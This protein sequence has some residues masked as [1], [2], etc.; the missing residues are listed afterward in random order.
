MGKIYTDW[1][2]LAQAGGMYCETTEDPM[3]WRSG[4]KTRRFEELANFDEV[5]K[6]L[7]LEVEVDY[8]EG[9]ALVHVKNP[10]SAGRMIL[11]EN[12]EVGSLVRYASSQEGNL[13]DLLAEYGQHVTIE[14]LIGGNKKR[15]RVYPVP[16]TTH[17]NT[18]SNIVEC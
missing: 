13:T 12:D 2:E 15:L 10:D 3:G 7:G 11:S 6:R 18:P 14:P 9:H 17:M 8:R 5:K 16:G 4:D 1:E